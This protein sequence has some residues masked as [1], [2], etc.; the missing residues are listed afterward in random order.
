VIGKEKAYEIADRYLIEYIGNLVGP[1][2]PIF[3]NKINVWIVPIFHMSKVATFRLGEMII[4]TE[5]DIIYVPTAEEMDKAGSQE[6]PE[7]IKPKSLI[8]KE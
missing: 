7:K 8:I 2:E 4:G 5:G 3:D 6:F 1:G